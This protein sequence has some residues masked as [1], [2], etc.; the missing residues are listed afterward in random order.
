MLNFLGGSN[1]LCGGL[2]RRDF[3]SIGSLGFGMGSL[4]LADL[5]R[6]E[7]ALSKSDSIRKP[8]SHKGLINI[9]LGGGPP[10]QDMWEIKTEAP[11]E[12]RIPSHINQ[13]SRHSDLRGVPATRRE[14]GQSGCHPLG[15]WLQRST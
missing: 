11:S 2:T 5:L 8:K 15:G 4:G 13:C 10:H 1:Q 6:A 9:F 12:M 7:D 3:L 14:D